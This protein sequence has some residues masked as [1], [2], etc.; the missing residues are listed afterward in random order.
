[1]NRSSLVVV[2]VGIKFVSHLST[3]AKAYISQADN[4][5]YLLNDPLMKYW[6]E[7]LN[8]NSESLDHLY[9]KH[10]LRYDSYEAITRYILKV[11]YQ[12]KHVCVVMYG[13]PAVFAQ[14]ALDAVR[15]AKKNGYFAKILPAISAEDCLFA[16]LLIDPGSCGCQSFEATD[17]LIHD[18]QFDPKCHL[19]LWQVGVIGALGH[20]KD[21]SNKA[22]INIL[23][24]YLRQFYLSQH[25]ITVY[26]ASQ[27]P[28]FESRI[29]EVM[30]DQL[31]D[32]NL[33]RITTLYIPPS[34]KAV[35]NEAML[36]ALEMNMDDLR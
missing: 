16:D 6:I 23:T 24:N 26:E 8:P 7:Q 34:N 33:S 4:V 32:V 29:E 18:R 14:P 11:L 9:A 12:H 17:F 13:H 30:L 31:P 22:G 28:S 25:M 20:V 3:E 1:M 36:K 35:C 27:Y 5:L 2:G 15:E 19:I 21:Q 10:E